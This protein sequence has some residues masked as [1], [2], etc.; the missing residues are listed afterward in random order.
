[1]PRMFRTG[2]GKGE[3]LGM[4]EIIFYAREARTIDSCSIHWDS[5]PSFIPLLPAVAFDEWLPNLRS[6]QVET[7]AGP[8]ELVGHEAQL[9]ALDQFEEWL[10]DVGRLSH[11]SELP[12][13]GALPLVAEAEAIPVAQAELRVRL[14]RAKQRVWSEESHEPDD[15][16]DIVF[17]LARKLLWD[18]AVSGAAVTVDADELIEQM[19]RQCEYLARARYSVEL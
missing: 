6:L 5:D 3:L 7:H 18:W 19:R 11:A 4:A 15:A 9:L 12:L 16:G 8:S 13:F 10:D 17:S 1:M 14:N 2:T